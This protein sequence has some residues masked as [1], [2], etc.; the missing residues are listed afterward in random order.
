AEGLLPG[1]SLHTA[2][3]AEMRALRRVHGD[4]YLASLSSAGTFVKIVGFRPGDEQAERLVAAQRAMVGGTLQAARLAL[5]SGGIAVNLGGGLHHAFADRGE[6]FCVFNDIAVATAELRAAGFA[7]RVLIV[8]LDLHDGDGTRATLAADPNVHLLS[9]HNHTNSDVPETPTSTLVE[10]GTAVDDAAY[11]QAIAEHLPP[12][13]A[14]VRPQLVVYL[15]GCD[16]AADDALGDWKITAEGMLARDRKVLEVVQR[17]ET[18]APVVILLA[19]GYGP[20][21]WRYSARF[22]ASLL[23]RGRPLEPP[24]TEQSTLLTYRRL[25]REPGRPRPPRAAAAD[26]WGLRPDDLHSALGGPQRPHKLLGAFPL[27]RLELAIEHAGLLDR[28]RAMGFTRPT[29]ELEVGHPFGDTLRVYGDETKGELLCELRLRIDRRTVAAHNL[30]RI[31]WLLL[32]NPRRPFTADRQPLPGQRFPGLGM[33]QDVVALLIVASERLQLD[34]ILIVPGH[35]HTAVQA[36]RSL[37]FLAPE[38]EGLFRS[39]QRAL[40]GLSLPAAANAVAA[41]RV[42]ETATGRP[43]TWRPMP[44]VF[45]TAETLAAQ[46]EGE[47]YERSAVAAADEQALTLAAE[48]PGPTPSAG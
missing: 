30:L 21:T 4:D 33:L 41:G 25:T 29:F 7:G 3:P 32:Q 27:S 19:G 1:G 26:D 14:R 23:R 9:L 8:D 2:A 10:L 38:D 22:F 31:E 5:A 13:F 42:H 37:R 48:A 34:G 45:P 43:F 11:L 12:L 17:G 15:A 40:S 35:Y 44:M 6:R 47:E 18:R 36:R 20:G 46:V 39:L 28:L 24:T 16:P